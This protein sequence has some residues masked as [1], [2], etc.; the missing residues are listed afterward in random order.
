M[1]TR[2]IS[3]VLS[4]SAPLGLFPITKP[5]P[6]PYSSGYAGPRQR[7]MNEATPREFAPKGTYS[8]GDGESRDVVRVGSLAYKGVPSLGFFVH[9]LAVR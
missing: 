1:A 2:K 7:D 9:S 4:K 6:A 3:T 5:V 8:P